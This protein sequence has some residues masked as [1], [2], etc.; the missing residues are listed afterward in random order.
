MALLLLFSCYVIRFF[1]TP[2]TA[3]SQAPLSSTV[4]PSLFIES[5]MLSNHLILCRPLLLLSSVFPSIGI[6]SSESALHLWLVLTVL[7]S[8]AFANNTVVIFQRRNWFR[9]INEACPSSMILFKEVF[10]QKCVLGKLIWQC[11]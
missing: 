3:A 2:G 6:F 11:V 9:E 5:V 8:T 1:V 4:S 10:E 7:D